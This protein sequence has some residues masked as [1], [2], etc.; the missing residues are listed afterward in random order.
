MAILISGVGRSGT[1]AFY[2]AIGKGLLS[3]HPDGRCVYEPY[4]WHIPNAE[5]S[6]YVKDEPF[7]VE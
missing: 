1:T 6:A 5:Q 4:L 7:T 2:Q 3:Q